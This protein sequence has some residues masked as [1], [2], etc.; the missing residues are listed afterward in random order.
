MEKRWYW[1]SVCG[2]GATEP[3]RRSMSARHALGAVKQ[4]AYAVYGGIGFGTWQCD[5]AVL[6]QP[7]GSLEEMV[8]D[9]RRK[10]SVERSRLSGFRRLGCVACV[11][12]G[13]A[14]AG[15]VRQWQ[16]P[17]EMTKLFQIND[18]NYMQDGNPRNLHY[19]FFSA[20]AWA[21]EVPRCLVAIAGH[22]L[23]GQNSQC[24]TLCQPP[25]STIIS[26]H[27]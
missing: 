19:Y 12:C 5:V 2:G 7:C 11:A 13:A 3:N 1:S 10:L 8:G 20:V 23:R 21:D 24:S 6:T 26:S 14:L 25:G 15:L 16:I 17:P 9:A 27:A 4:L 18:F 22:T